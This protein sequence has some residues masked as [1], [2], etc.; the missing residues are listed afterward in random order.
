[1]Q[2]GRL[3]VFR[4]GYFFNSLG[5]VPW[6]NGI[7]S[8]KF[9]AKN[10]TTKDTNTMRKFTILFTL[11]ISFLAT[12]A[13]STAANPPDCGDACP[14]VKSAAANPP[15]C[16]DACPWVKSTAANPPDCGDACP[17]VK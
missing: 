12:A 5:L 10:Q 14:W 11:T 6:R 17:W 4:I 1:L 3:R 13:T 16:G 9:E 7:E 2:T 15:D 8:K